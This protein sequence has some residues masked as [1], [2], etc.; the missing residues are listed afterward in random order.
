MVIFGASAFKYICWIRSHSV[1]ICP[2][3]GG[4]HSS[5]QGVQS[6]I[7]RPRGAP[8]PRLAPL[9]RAQHDNGLSRDPDHGPRSWQLP[10]LVWLCLEQ[11]PRNPQGELPIPLSEMPSLL[12]EKLHWVLASMSRMCCRLISNPSSS[13][14]VPTGHHPAAPVLSRHGDAD[15]EVHTLPRALRSPSVWGA[16]LIVRCQDQQREHDKVSTESQRNVPGPGHGADLLPPGGRVS[17]V[18]RAAETQWRRHPAVSPLAHKWLI[19]YVLL[20]YVFALLKIFYASLVVFSKKHVLTHH[21]HTVRYSSSV[22]RCAIPLRWSSPCKR[23]PRSTATTLC[24]SS[25][26]WKEHLTSPAAF[27]TDTLIRLETVSFT[28]GWD[29]G[30]LEF[31]PNFG[32]VPELWRDHE[33]ENVQESIQE[34]V[35][36]HRGGHSNK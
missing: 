31:S 35:T 24:A 34:I 30:N 2:E 10:G 5:H 17:P 3:L 6:L 26:W 22:R 14:I 23:S 18:Q 1:S 29:W 9:A 11:N 13:L 33:W 36:N 19:V 7:S 28:N 4:S 20:K 15:W 16:Y 21:V 12:P 25:S 27:C 8:A 32:R